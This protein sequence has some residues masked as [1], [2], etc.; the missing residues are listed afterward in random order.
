MQ[1]TLFVAFK[2]DGFHTVMSITL[3][4]SAVSIVKSFEGMEVHVITLNSGIL[5]IKASHE[6]LNATQGTTV[7]TK[8]GSY[9]CLIGRTIF[10]SE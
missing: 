4:N 10:A 9:L 2:D 5:I 1:H 6:G 3:S 8:D 7:K